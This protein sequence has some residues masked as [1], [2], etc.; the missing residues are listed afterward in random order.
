MAPLGV[1]AGLHTGLIFSEILSLIVD[2]LRVFRKFLLTSSDKRDNYRLGG[3]FY[4]LEVRRSD[5]HH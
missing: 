2:F 5:R 1:G 4:R 3:H